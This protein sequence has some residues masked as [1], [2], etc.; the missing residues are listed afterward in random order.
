MNN[1][2][3]ND[4]TINEKRH[5]RRI[6]ANYNINFIYDVAAKLK[7]KSD[8]HSTA[9]NKFAA[10]TKNI[11]ASGL[12]FITNKEL[13]EG[14]SLKIQFFLPKSKV[15]INMEGVVKWIKALELSNKNRYETGV[16]INTINGKSVADT[17][18]Y[19]EQYQVEWSDVLES[20]FGKYN[21]VIR[22]LNK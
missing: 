1:I 14:D 2:K 11:S 9:I 10:L 15:S 21:T 3:I 19:D 16:K 17:I 18:R 20:V 4:E 5:H 22:S 8:N 6:D 12:G 13:C 7:G